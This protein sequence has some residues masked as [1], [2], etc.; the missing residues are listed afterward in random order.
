[1]FPAPASLTKSHCKRE[2]TQASTQPHAMGGKRN[3]GTPKGARNNRG[4]KD[5]N[6]RACTFLLD[7]SSR[8]H[9]EE[10]KSQILLS[11]LCSFVAFVMM[12][13]SLLALCT[14]SLRR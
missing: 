2:D 6:I 1:M 4:R 5:K 12:G 10:L 3:Y 14:T 9:R 7:G 11:G 13:T 8:N